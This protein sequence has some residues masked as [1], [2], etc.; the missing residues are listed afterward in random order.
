MEE[1]VDKDMVLLAAT[2]VSLATTL[3]DFSQCVVALNTSHSKKDL[4]YQMQVYKEAS[5]YIFEAIELLE[6]HLAEI[7]FCFNDMNLSE[8]V[9]TIRIPLHQNIRQSMTLLYPTFSEVILLLASCY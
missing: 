8:Q 7:F 2:E 5:E 3:R 6:H 1:D 4:Q 9:E